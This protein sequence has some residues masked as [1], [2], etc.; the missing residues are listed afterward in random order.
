MSIIPLLGPYIQSYM[1]NSH[2]R[3][4]HK[5][6]SM[7]NV[8]V[9]PLNNKFMKMTIFN[10]SFR[11]SG[12]HSQIFNKIEWLHKLFQDLGFLISTDRVQ[13]FIQIL[14]GKR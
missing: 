1:R 3:K 11:S 12:G 2:R 14:H 4:Y 6:F 8:Y 5:S 7:Q 10:F 13:F 9:F